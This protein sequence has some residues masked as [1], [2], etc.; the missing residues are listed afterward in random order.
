M[1]PIENNP[2]LEIPSEFNS[3]FL[4]VTLSSNP[5]ADG[6]Y[7][8]MDLKNSARGDW[9]IKPEYAKEIKY[10]FPVKKNKILGVLE[11]LGFDEV[12]INGK[13]RIRFNLKPIYEGSHTMISQA[14]YDV[15]KTNYVVKLFKL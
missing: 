15:N 4:N 8:I 1:K 3:A 12:D 7:S 9:W 2:S 11:V 13:T 14:N 10:V 5:G 6:R